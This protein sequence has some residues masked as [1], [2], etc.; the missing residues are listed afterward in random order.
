MR[1][2]ASPWLKPLAVA[3]SALTAAVFG[4]GTMLALPAMAATGAVDVTWTNTSEWTTGVQ[5]AVT[6]ENRSAGQLT[7]WQVRFT[8]GNTVSSI[9]DATQ[10]PTAGGF[11]AKAPAYAANIAAGGKAAFGLVGTKVAGAA[12][13]P[14][15]CTVILPT[16]AAPIAC[17]I[18]GVL[19]ATVPTSPTAPA[20]TATPTPTPTK[21]STP[22][23]TPTPT[24]PVTLPGGGSVAVTWTNT[25]EWAAG[26][27]SSVRLTNTSTSPIAPWEI[28]FTYGNVVNSLWDGTSAVVAGGFDVKAPSYAQVLAAGGTATFGLTSNKVAGSPLFPTACAVV[29]PPTPVSCTVNNGTPTT[30]T[31]TPTPS[32]T[33][34]P[35]PT[36]TP[37]DPPVVTPPAAGALLVAPYV[38][39]GIWPTADLSSVASQTGT[40]ALT[41]SFVVADRSSACSPTWAGYTAYTIGGS[42]DFVGTV[43]AFQAKGGRM[44]VSFG[45]SVN[46]EIARVCTDP[47]KV[48]AAYTKVVTRFNL[49]RIDFDIEGTDVSDSTS[50]KRRAAA[51]ATLQAQRAAA[52]HP[53]QVT[54]TL[55]VMPTGLL[56]SALRTITEFQAA[57]VK[58]TAID[59][60]AMDYGLGTKDMGAAAVS[61]IQA[62]ANQLGTLPAYAALTPAQR[63]ALVGVIPLIGVQDTA[64]ETF[65]LANAT[66][67]AAWAKANRIASLGWWETTRDQPCTG[68][69]AAYMCTGVS[70]SQWAY[71]KAFVAAAR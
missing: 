69:I 25:S 28:R 24:S 31:P 37:T 40:N 9:W 26:F 2:D 45:G 12:L 38:D 67:V 10:T 20:P 29:N 63:L 64:G 34:T 33:Q 13:I 70:A 57:G 62:T 30:S 58:L 32:P 44:I 8:Y 4:I 48:L 16:G 42:Q 23:P 1:N 11:I 5:A 18:N 71:A 7:G 22:T 61:A 3:V 46:D 65:T 51:V 17:A 43:S 35:T 68:G 6:I 41:A 19:S 50:N 59:I 52:G 54:L 55:P 21:T 56:A 39:M 14:T 15:G 47:A 36:P 27:Q 49:D 60:M 66:T 53:L